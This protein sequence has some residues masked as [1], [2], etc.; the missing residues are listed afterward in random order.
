LA[1]STAVLF[2]SYVWAAACVLAMASFSRESVGLRTMSKSG[3][4]WF[5]VSGTMIAISQIFRYGALAYAP[6]AVVVPIQRLSIIFRLGFNILINR[7]YER[8][9]LSIIIGIVLS[10][11]GA[12]ALGMDTETALNWLDLGPGLTEMLNWRF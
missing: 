2:F 7:D 4:N 9:D 11:I 12:A 5:M 10:V 3:L 6:V 8:F 1:N